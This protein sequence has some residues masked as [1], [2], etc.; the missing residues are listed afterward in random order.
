MPFGIRGAIWYQG[1]SN[2]STH[3]R[4]T[5]F[6]KMQQLIGGW[7]AVWGEGDF[8]FYFVQIAPYAYTKQSNGKALTDDLPELW[9][10][11]LKSLAIPHTGMAVITDLVTD[12]RNIHP[13]QKLEVGERLALW[14]LANDYGKKDLVFS[15][16]LFGSFNSST[17]DAVI[18]FDHAQGLTN[19]RWKTTN[20]F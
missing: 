14:A 13:P 4:L 12:F 19:A 5:Y 3:D 6:D 9:E 1:E 11:Q 7:R 15:G 20:R 8:P 17:T 18:H 2:V 10:A 16:P